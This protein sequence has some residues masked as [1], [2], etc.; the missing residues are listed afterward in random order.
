MEPSWRL[1]EQF[2]PVVV[3]YALDKDNVESTQPMNYATEYPGGGATT[4]VSYQ[5]CKKQYGG[6]FFAGFI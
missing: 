1:M 2:V 5:K 4:Y 3:Q 6:S